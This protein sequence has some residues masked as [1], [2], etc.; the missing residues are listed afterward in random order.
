M[1]RNIL[2][3]VAGIVTAI[4]TFILAETINATFHSNSTNLDV[5]QNPALLF[6][7]LGGWVIGSLLCGFIIKWIS[8]KGNKS[9]PLI[10]GSILTLSAIANF[11][12]IPHPIWFIIVGS[13]IFIPAT[14]FGHSL[15]K[16]K[17]YE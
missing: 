17:T 9:L 16:T 8:K 1:I 11:I 10:A 12:S 14:L 6:I 5:N 3:I 15:F 4:I 7:V 13:L 2:S